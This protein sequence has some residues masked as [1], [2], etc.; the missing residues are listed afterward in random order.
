MARNTKAESAQLAERRAMALRL[1]LRGRTYER[2]A[3][4]SRAEGWLPRPY[5]SRQAVHEDMKV[6]LAEYKA[7]QNEMAGEWVAREAAKLD[8]LEEEA[9]NVLESLHYVVSQ[10]ELVYIHEREPQLKKQGWARPKLADP[11]VTE[12]LEDAKVPL[13]DNKPVLDA[14]LVLLKIAE[15]RAK[16]LG[17]DAPIKKQVEVSGAGAVG[18]KINEVIAGLSAGFGNLAVP[19]GRVEDVAGGGPGEAAPAAPAA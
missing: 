10:G 4:I 18:D 7:A 12:A 16:L 9:W 3:E 19:I 17:L 14:L 13:Q 2:I 1:N 6:A 8:I 15:R 11:V 5:N